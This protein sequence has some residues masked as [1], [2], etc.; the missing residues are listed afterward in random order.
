MIPWFGLMAPFLFSKRSSGI[1]AN[2]SLYGA[3]IVLSYSGTPR[4]LSFLLTPMLFCK[5]FA[6]LGSSNKSYH[7]SLLTAG[8]RSALVTLPFYLVFLFSHTLRHIWPELFTLSSYSSIRLLGHSII[9]QEMNATHHVG[10]F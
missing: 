7:L 10:F 5:F 6:Y 1:L 3:K 8:C 4:L 2:C 9:I